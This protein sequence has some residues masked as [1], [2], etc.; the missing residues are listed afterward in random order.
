MN[1]WYVAQTQVRGEATAERHLERQGFRAYLPRYLKSRRHARK[2]DT[3]AAP[4]FPGYLFISMDVA[5]TRWRAIRSTVGVKSLICTGDSPLPVPDGVV[6]DILARADEQGIVPM[7]E[8]APFEKGDTVQVTQGPLADQVGW[9]ECCTDD[10]RVVVLLNLL[11]RQL[12][13]PLPLGAVR[14]FA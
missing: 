14:A 2:T 5:R 7:R 3:I 10:Q 4:L 8:P 13:V 6:E 11:G 9:F 12:R 1:R